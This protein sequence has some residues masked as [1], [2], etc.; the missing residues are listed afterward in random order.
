MDEELRDLG[1]LA[2]ALAGGQPRQLDDAVAEELEAPDLAIAVEHRQ[3]SV[4]AV[5]DGNPDALVE[6]KAAVSELV[7]GKLDLAGGGKHPQ[8][9]AGGVETTIAEKLLEDEPVVAA[10][11]LEPILEDVHELQGLF[12]GHPSFF[13]HLLEDRREVGQIV[14]QTETTH[15]GVDHAGSG[16]VERPGSRCDGAA[17]R[18]LEEHELIVPV[19]HH[20][21]A[22]PQRPQELEAFQAE[23]DLDEL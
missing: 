3:Q 21:D 12:L 8:R 6:G 15:R 17:H 4:V 5:V 11:L 14:D 23:P 18:R 13:S 10:D 7:V 22:P 19:R 2:R 1:D 9:P 16:E 20:D